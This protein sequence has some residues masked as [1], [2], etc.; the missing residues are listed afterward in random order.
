[1]LSHACRFL[2]DLSCVPAIA[3]SCLDCQQGEAATMKT[4][5]FFAVT[6][7]NGLVAQELQATTRT[8]AIAEVKAAISDRSA[9]A[10]LDCYQAAL[11]EA[12]G[13]FCSNASFDEALELCGNAGARF[14]WDEQSDDTWSVWSHTA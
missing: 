9:Q 10:W 12:C 14:V 6:N 1:M 2:V 7:S 5:K 3:E 8:E 13:V 11:E 4:T